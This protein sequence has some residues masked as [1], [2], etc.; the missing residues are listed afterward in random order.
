[1]LLRHDV[2]F[3]PAANI[4]DEAHAIAVRVAGGQ[5]DSQA[6][7]SVREKWARY[8]GTPA[9]S[10][11]IA[12][13]EAGH[14][15]G[16]AQ[17]LHRLCCAA[18]ELFEATIDV[19]RGEQYREQ[20]SR[21]ARELAELRLRFAATCPLVDELPKESAIHRGVVIA[22]IFG[23]DK[24]DREIWQS[25]RN[26]LAAA[27]AVHL[28]PY[29][30]QG[31]R[32]TIC[33]FRYREHEDSE[34]PKRQLLR[35]NPLDRRRL[36]DERSQDLCAPDDGH[37]SVSYFLV[38]E[39][40]GAPRPVELLLRLAWL[41]A[42]YSAGHVARYGSA[43][44]FWLCA[45][46]ASVRMTSSL[47]ITESDAMFDHLSQFVRD[48]SLKN[49]IIVHPEMLARDHSL[50]L[51]FAPTWRVPFQHRKACKSNVEWLMTTARFT[52]LP[53]DEAPSELVCE[54]ED[55]TIECWG[56]PNQPA[57]RTSPSPARRGV[58]R[59]T[60]RRVVRCTLDLGERSC[61][62]L[63]LDYSPLG[64]RIVLPSAGA[65]GADLK[66]QQIY[67][68]EMPAGLPWP[69]ERGRLCKPYRA[70][71][72]PVPRSTRGATE[73]PRSERRPPSVKGGTEVRLRFVTPV[74]GTE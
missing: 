23:R 4:L 19:H 62:A 16:L 30:P 68:L 38:L 64:C 69:W 54:R 14:E 7:D 74:P 11:A 72:T 21:L 9:L 51:W 20:A 3:E 47:R 18:D 29:E 42:S 27:N 71:V 50:S 35:P 53:G 5:A 55:L 58:S 44:A 36:L 39:P 65:F 43:F 73:G 31:G 66:L 24:G 32:R 6:F 34:P 13:L 67:T 22:L 2:E 46:P 37:Y 41:L 48:R 33:Q 12:C 45:C 60:L 15:S 8:R 10:E 63:L 59:L 17:D 28:T 1:M 57:P 49:C 61:Q 56:R 40:P 70:S 52:G 25:V 26:Q